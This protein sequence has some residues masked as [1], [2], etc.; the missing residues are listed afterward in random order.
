[1][2]P[3]QRSAACLAGLQVRG[4]SKRFGPVVALDDVDLEVARGEVRALLGE[5]GAGKTTLMNIVFGLIRPDRGEIR[6][7][8]RRAAWA[9]PREALAAGVSMVHQHFSLIPAFTVLENLML[10]ARAGRRLFLDEQATRR[11]AAQLVESYGFDLRL[12]ARVRD[13]PVG[14][15]QRAEIARALFRGADVLILDEPTAVL[16]VREVR[17][18]FDLL[19]R[20]REGGATVVFITHKLDEALAISDRVTVLRG[21]RVVGELDAR[22][23]TP[24][25]LA[26]LM[27]ARD[28]PAPAARTTG[29]RGEGAAPPLAVRGLSVRGEGRTLVDRVDLRVA[30]GEIVGVAGVAGNGQ[31]ELIAAITGLRVPDAGVV[32]I[33]GVVP[34]PGSRAAFLACGAAVIPE[35]RQATGLV[36]ELSVQDN[37]MLGLQREAR[38]SSRALLRRRAAESYAEDLIARYGIKAGGLRTPVSALSGGHQQRVILARELE[39]APRL[40]VAVQPT[41]GLDL[42]ASRF[43]HEK[44]LEHREAGAGCL[45]VSTDIDEL[46]A[47]TDRL[48]VMYRGRV[49]GEVPT[50]GADL[51][52]IGLMM[53]GGATPGS[54]S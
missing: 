44:L 10:G 28:L 31:E 46:L 7:D 11:K 25:R 23:A 47:V 40:I 19:R 48:L 27:V 36:P 41:R 17:P 2:T 43:V 21:G 32:E 50:A 45:L 4:V 33:A 35:D 37:L 5:N 52:R 6:L 29:P 18:F 8:G 49:A 15:Q 38:F 22:D 13:L 30:A 24:Q 12:D 26:A 51:E 39:K 20:L 14:A 34:R 9:S 16:G 54:A 42:A 3:G 53:G 1:V